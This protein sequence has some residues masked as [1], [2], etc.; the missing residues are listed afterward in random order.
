MEREQKTGEEEE[1]VHTPMLTSSPGQDNHLLYCKTTKN[2][3][4]DKLCF[5]FARLND[6]ATNEVIS[7]K[8]EK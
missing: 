5:K 4:K 2:G 3:I 6:C 7:F 8:D 1:E